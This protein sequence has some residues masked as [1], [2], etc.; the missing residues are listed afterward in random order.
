[1][2]EV[3]EPGEYFK[4]KKP[5]ISWDGIAGFKDAK[6]R[7]EE[8]VSLPLKHPSTFEKAGIRPHIGVLIWGPSDSGFNALAEAAAE[9]AGSNYISAKAE[10]LNGGDGSV[11]ALYEAAA[12]L[13]PCV[14]YIGD[15]EALAPR[16]EVQASKGKWA[17]SSVTRILFSEI[18]SIAQR[19]DV[20]TVTATRYPE[21]LDPAL[22]RN[23][24][25]DRKIYV[26]APDYYDRLEVLKAALKKT[27]VGGDVELEKLAEAAEGYSSGDLITL[28]REATLFAIKER[29]DDFRDVG[30]KHF[31][32]AMERIPPAIDPAVVKR[33]EEIFREECKHRYMY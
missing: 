16:R 21:L 15:I 27:P 30:F 17:S 29:G 1:M 5:G 13:A 22:L 33:H 32:E 12:E 19:G 7:L 11:T 18:D 26:P 23:G 8:M 3:L 6:E 2:C 25:V 14:V 20:I 31:E 10:D 28:T 4:V 24:R 9:S